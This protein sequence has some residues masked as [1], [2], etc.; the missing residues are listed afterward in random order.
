MGIARTWVRV[1]ALVTVVD[2]ERRKLFGAEGP[3][4]ERKEWI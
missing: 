4:D 2:E 3:G 1:E